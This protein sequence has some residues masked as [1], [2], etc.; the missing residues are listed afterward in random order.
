MASRARKNRQVNYLDHVPR[1]SIGH[2]ETEDGQL[3][4]LRPKFI[5]G[6]LARWLQPRIKR[7]FFR[8][9]LDEVGTAT[10]QAIDGNRNVGEIA[11]LLYEQFGE[12]IEPRY[13]RMSRFIDSLAK[14]AMVTFEP[15]PAAE[16]G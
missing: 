8:V 1:R 11:D 13:E 6:P 5:K 2:E 16:R 14:G 7:K 4:L 3:V 9:R 10:W 12:R 15:S